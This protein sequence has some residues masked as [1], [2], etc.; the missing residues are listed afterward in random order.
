MSAQIERRLVSSREFD[1]GPMDSYSS[2]PKSGE[3]EG[4][5]KKDPE[6]WSLLSL[7]VLV[8]KDEEEG[9]SLNATERGEEWSE[10][11]EPSQ[12]QHASLQFFVLPPRRIRAN[13]AAA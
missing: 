3:R 6:V 5:A 13:Q 9:V 4:V 11:D 10:L 8:G 1:T 12:S 7:V 2:D